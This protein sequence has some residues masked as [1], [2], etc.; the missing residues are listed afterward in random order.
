M[1]KEKIDMASIERLKSDIQDAK[2]E[3]TK[4]KAVMGEVTDN[5]TKEITALKEL[6][7]EIPER[8]KDMSDEEY[9][10][11]II[12]RAEKY[13]DKLNDEIDDK[14]KEIEEIIEKWNN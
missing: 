3:L 5:L 8:E 11:D 10:A 6:G 14:K 2:D 13:S 4:A 9:Y 7:V 12:K 1:V